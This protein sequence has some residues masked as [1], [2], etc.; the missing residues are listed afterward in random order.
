VKG[1]RWRRLRTIEPFARHTQ[2]L[3]KL[4]NSANRKSNRKRGAWLGALAA[5]ILFWPVA[6]EVHRASAQDTNS[7]N[8]GG[9]SVEPS[10]EIFATM[11]ALDAAGFQADE[12]TLA[13]MPERLKLRGDLLKLHG[14]AT[15]A[16][17]RFYRDHELGSPGET[18]S[19]YITFG[20]V[21]GAPPRFEYQMDYDLLPP[22][23]ISIENFQ[24]IL[25]NFY[26][27]AG[28]GAQWARIEPEYESS[29]AQYEPIVRRI[30]ISTNS[31]LREILKPSTGRTF[32]VYVE[33]LVGQ[34]TNFR[35][36]GDH[37]AIVVG[38][39]QPLPVAD[40]QHA[41]L[42]F[43]LDPLPLKY[44]DSL[45]AKSALL[46]IAARAPELPPEYQTDFNNFADECLVKS[47]ELRLRRL[48]PDQEEAALKQDDE[49]GYTMVRPIV[50]QLKKFEKSEPSLAY[51]FPDLIAGIDVAAEQKRLQGIVFA[52]PQSAVQAEAKPAE[53]APKS[54]TDQLLNEGD[55]QIALQNPAAAAAA[56]QKVLD[57]DPTQPKA[58]YG[59]AVASL[60]SK[61]GDKAMELFEAVV[62]PPEGSPK[63]APDPAILAW[64]HIYLG[65]LYDIEDERGQAVQHYRAAL[66]VAGAP[67]AARV[68]AQR[69][70][71]EAYKAPGSSGSQ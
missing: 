27:E 8:N 14:P 35:N 62:S 46:N 36:Y 44:R 43:M 34:L 51:Y 58:L 12:S 39:A 70:I 67:E 55:R 28:L 68:A 20:L 40:I 45:Q 31:Y 50:Q 17:R 65:R 11:C 1:L 19:R 13:E 41:Y 64:S 9:I 47:V 38:A 60:M 57:K 53:P 61:Q 32:T 63:T 48:P 10:E 42:H 23:V 69:G 52:K 71:D 24:P 66:A 49:S 16:L 7:A 21:I 37:Y 29:V 56:F 2:G 6:G 25:A 4:S 15:E 5:M 18:L 54:E 30:V 33:P 59:L 22:D 26:R 3:V